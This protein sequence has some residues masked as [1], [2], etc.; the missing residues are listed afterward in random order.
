MRTGKWFWNAP[1]STPQTIPGAV[2][3]AD[4]QVLRLI[5]VHA[6]LELPEL[7]VHQPWGDDPAG[8]ADPGWLTR[9]RVGHE[10]PALGWL[11]AVCTG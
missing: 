11:T 6:H 9:G 1:Y 2:A 8:N 4:G 5:V 10:S 7:A 3:A